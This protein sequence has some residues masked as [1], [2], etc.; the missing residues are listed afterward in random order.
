MKTSQVPAK[1]VRT[2]QGSWTP[3]SP[4]SPHPSRRM[5]VWPSTGVKVSA[6]QTLRV[7]M[8]YS[9]ARPRPCQRFTCRLAAT[10]A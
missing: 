9:P 3:W 10:G 5:P 2:C 4:S 1:D 7:S 6:L 8:L